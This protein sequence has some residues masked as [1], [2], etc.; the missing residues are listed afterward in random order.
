MSRKAKHDI[1]PVVRSA[2]LRALERI[3]EEDGK[4][5]SEIIADWMR[6]DPGAVLNAVSKFTVR[7]AN[8]KG[9]VSHDHSGTV[10]HKQEPADLTKAWLEGV[11]Q[12]EEDRVH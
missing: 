6:K 7:E 11:M 9:Q 12:D 4:T 8:V 10:V 1:A 3:K 2:F 5:F